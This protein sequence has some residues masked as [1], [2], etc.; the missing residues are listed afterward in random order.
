MDFL[1]DKIA[2]FV[3]KKPMWAFLLVILFFIIYF[4]IG[5]NLSR[6]YTEDEYAAAKLKIL[7]QIDNETL[8]VDLYDEV[9]YKVYSEAAENNIDLN[10]VK[11][12][13]EYEYTMFLLYDFYQLV[14]DEGLGGYL[15]STDFLFAYEIEELLF[16]IGMEDLA[17]DYRKVLEKNNMDEDAFIKDNDDNESLYEHLRIKELY[18]LYPSMHTFDNAFDTVKG[19]HSFIEKLGTYA[20]RNIDSYEYYA[21]SEKQLEIELLKGL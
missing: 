13:N 2:M 14:K 16:S 21:I 3:A 15:Y 19:N 8:C 1:K 9:Y 6:D 11:E 10:A 18:Q 7:S 17:D 20:R 4:G 12:L 5:I